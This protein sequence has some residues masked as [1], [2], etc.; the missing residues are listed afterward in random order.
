MPARA[1][2]LNADD[3]GYDPA[4]T[5]GILRALREGVVSSTTF[6][7]NTPHSLAAAQQVREGGGALAIGLHLNLARGAPL[8]AGFPEHLLSRGQLSE[9][10]AAALPP[11]VVEAEAHAQLQR[12]EQLLG[13]PA[14]HVDVHKHLHRH[15]DVL[16]GLA[17][18][19]RAAGLPVRSIDPAMRAALQARGVRTNDHF[20]GDAGAEAYWTLDELERRL[21]ALP[22]DGVVELMCHPGYAPETLQSGYAQQRE[23]ELH[24]FLH[25]RARALLAGAGV[26]VADFRVL[27][28]A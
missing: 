14:T 2:I 17:S 23:V 21:A 12:L 3:L 5:R 20:I 11:E 18:A 13:R 16:Q 10:Q 4:V 8:S 19:A 22:S 9:A 7:V 24:T 26:P 15:P 1:L 6:M 28:A 27:H 25:P